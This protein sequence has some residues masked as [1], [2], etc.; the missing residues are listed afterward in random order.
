[1]TLHNSQ[2]LDD[3]LGAWSDENLSLARFLG[4][5][6]GIERIVEDGGFDHVCGRRFSMACSRLR[7]L[8]VNILAFRS[9]S[10]KECPSVQDQR[11][12]QLLL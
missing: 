8:L 11:V 1:M 2:E 3:D 7:Y 12:L 5:V 10:Q 6:D 9:Q 4:V